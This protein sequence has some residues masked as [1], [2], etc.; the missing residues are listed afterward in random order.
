MKYLRLLVVTLI[1]CAYLKG[2]RQVVFVREDGTISEDQGQDLDNA[3]DEDRFRH[4]LKLACESL[5]RERIEWPSPPFRPDAR[6]RW[7]IIQSNKPG[8][9]PGGYKREWLSMD[10]PKAVTK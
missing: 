8:W 7:Q 2:E 4:E 3:T 9:M 10:M 6:F 5:E 1:C